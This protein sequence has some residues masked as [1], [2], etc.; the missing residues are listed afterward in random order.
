MNEKLNAT[1]RDWSKFDA[2]VITAEEYEEL[3]EL[4]DEQLDKADLYDGG[5]LIRRGRPKADRTKKAVTIRYSPEVIEA[6]KAT[7]RGWQTRIDNALK[8]WLREH[9]AA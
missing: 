2:H 9:P 8:D 6:F 5:K 7:G 4:T 3:P 1:P